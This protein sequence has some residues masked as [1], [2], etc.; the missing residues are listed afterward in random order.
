MAK[1]SLKWDIIKA[2]QFLT[3]KGIMVEVKLIKAKNEDGHEM[4]AINK[5]Y[6]HVAIDKDKAQDLIKAI[7]E[8]CK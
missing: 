3:E 8:V 4:I 1:K 5:L 6:S 7:K 2:V